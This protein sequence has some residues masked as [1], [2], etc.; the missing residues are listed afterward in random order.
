MSII[1]YSQDV[2]HRNLILENK[3]ML[4][5]DFIADGLLWSFQDLQ[6]FCAY[7]FC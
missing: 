6:N 2:N 1:V 5:F 4:S 3:N 7:A